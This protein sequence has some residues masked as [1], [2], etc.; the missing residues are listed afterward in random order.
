MYFRSVA[1]TL[2]ITEVPQVH[3]GDDPSS[4]LPD[5]VIA[6]LVAVGGYPPAR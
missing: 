4:V 5:L 1:G 3:D 6:D 2:H